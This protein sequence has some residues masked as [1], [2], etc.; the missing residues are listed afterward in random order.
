MKYSLVFIFICLIFLGCTNKEVSGH[1][2]FYIKGEFKHA[3][4]IQLFY[5]DNYFNSYSEKNSILQKIH[6]SDSIQCL[7]FNLPEGYLPTRLRIDLGQN[8]KQKLIT[9]SGLGICYNNNCK[10]FNTFDLLNSFEFNKN[11]KYHKKT[12]K[13]FLLEIKGEVYDPYFISKNL[14]PILDSLKN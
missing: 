1:V 11:L 7:S 3:D 8:S 2:T 5:N 12:G 10:F 13:L 4:K 9:L 14:T 6:E